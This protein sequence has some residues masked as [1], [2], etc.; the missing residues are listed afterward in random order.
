MPNHATITHDQLRTL[1]RDTELGGSTQDLNRFTYAR[2]GNSTYTFGLPQFDVGK[3]GTEV[4]EF[5]KE[6]GFTTNDIKKLSQHGGLSHTELK[7]LDATLQAIPKD[8]LDRFTNMQ[9]DKS[10]A[11]VNDVIDRVRKQNPAAAEAIVDDAKLQLGIAD[12][13]NQFGAAGPQFIGFLAG[14]PEKLIG[15]MV[16]AGDPPAREDVQKFINATGYGHDKANAKAVE[17]RAERFDEAMATLKLGPATKTASHATDR[18]VATLKQGRHGP[19]VHSLQAQLADLGYLDA[20]GIDGAFGIRTGRAVERFQHDHRLKVDGIAGPMTLK[21]L[22]QAH[23]RN[24]NPGLD[25]PTHADHALFQQA[26]RGVHQMDA[27]R[28]R[29]PDQHSDNLAA[30]LTVQARRNNLTRIDQVALGPDGERTFAVQHGVLT[31]HAQVPTDEAVQTSIEQSSAAWLQVMQQQ[32]PVQSVA[33][34]VTQHSL[35]AQGVGR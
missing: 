25:N 8:K 13:Q 17:S 5:L 10:I 11:G 15:G 19:A 35:P 30:A 9:L 26:Q 7:A 4:K 6:N 34:Q 24:T 22:D 29:I 12:Y 3:N 31:R 21:A 27:E 28:G 33:P 18:T 1:F 23:A 32:Q 16:Q 20:K 14:R 2:K